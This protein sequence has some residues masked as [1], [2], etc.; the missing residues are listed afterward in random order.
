MTLGAGW[1]PAHRDAHCWLWTDAL[2]GEALEFVPAPAS[3]LAFTEWQCGNGALAAMAVDRALTADPDYSMAQLL[4]G[5]VDVDSAFG[6]EDAHES[7]RCPPPATPSELAARRRRRPGQG[8]DAGRRGRGD[9]PAGQP[10]ALAGVVGRAPPTSER[11]TASAGRGRVGLV[12]VQAALASATRRAGLA[13]DD[14]GGLGVRRGGRAGARRPA[15]AWRVTSG[16]IGSASGREPGRRRILRLGQGRAA[17]R[18]ALRIAERRR[19]QAGRAPA[20]QHP[21]GAGSPAAAIAITLIVGGGWDSAQSLGGDRGPAE[22]NVTAPG[23]A[24]LIWSAASSYSVQPSTTASQP[25]GVSAAAAATAALVASSSPASTASARPGQA[26]GV[27]DAD[28]PN[29]AISRC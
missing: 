11:V 28:P 26:T 9:G 17:L 4:A 19:G 18:P 29:L 27:T 5:A 14:A 10:D 1:H 15:R 23:T 16:R 13:R 2:R 7:R 24:R 3:L 25:G 6:G 8:S 21:D 20:E 12:T 22:R